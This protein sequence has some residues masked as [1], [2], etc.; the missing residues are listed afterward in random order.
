MDRASITKALSEARSIVDEVLPWELKSGPRNLPVADR[1][2]MRKTAL[3]VILGALLSQAPAPAAAEDDDNGPALLRTSEAARLIGASDSSLYNW[4]RRGLLTPFRTPSGHRRYDRSQVVALR[5]S[6][7]GQR[8]AR[9]RNPDGMEDI[10][11]M[12]TQDKLSWEEIAAKTGTT[13]M[14]A[15]RSFDR[16]AARQQAS[17]TGP[18][19]DKS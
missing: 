7:F 17:V 8:S 2:E 3:Q 14:A 12:R 18:G 15:R 11:G 5:D 13:K 6:E 19:R 4:E 9:R 1:A 10:V 16:W